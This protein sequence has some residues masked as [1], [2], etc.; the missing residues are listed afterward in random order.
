MERRSGRPD[1]GHP[2]VQPFDLDLCP[3][4]DAIVIGPSC[5]KR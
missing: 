1:P 4:D 5:P 3:P 2:A